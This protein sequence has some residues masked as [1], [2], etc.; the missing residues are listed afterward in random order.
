ME[1]KEGNEATHTV[2]HASSSLSGLATVCW[3]MAEFH[4]QWLSS[5]SLEDLLTVSFV[6]Q[7]FGFELEMT[8]GDVRSVKAEMLRYSRV[9]NRERIKYKVWLCCFIVTAQGGRACLRYRRNITHNFL[10]E[11]VREE[12]LKRSNR[13]SLVRGPEISA[14]LPSRH[15]Q[16]TTEG[17]MI[18]S[19][20]HV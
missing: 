8:C 17:A 6:P 9:S 19:S 18:S 15:I 4:Q 10:S 20:G 7:I 2:E 11:F 5:R 13:S 14:T 1:W 3:T 16:N 12:I